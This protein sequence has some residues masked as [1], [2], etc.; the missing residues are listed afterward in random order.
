MK[1]LASDLDGTLLN[2][3]SQLSDR[4]EAVLRQASAAGI[5]IVAATGRSY[6]TAI[7]LFEGINGHGGSDIVRW[8]LCSNGATVYDAAAGDV[9]SH[10]LIDGSAARRILSTSD[11]LDG[12]GFA[13]ETASGRFR[14]EPMTKMM[15]ERFGTDLVIDYTDAPPM[16]EMADEL[17]KVLIF[18][19]DLD[20]DELLAELASTL[21]DGMSVSSSGFAFIEITAAGAEKGAALAALCDQLGIDRADTVAFGDQRNDLGMISWAGRGYAMDN[22]HP[23]VLALTELRAPHHNE[24]GVAVVVEQLL[25]TASPEIP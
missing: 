11:V 23:E 19:R 6:R 20:H 18:H 1:L 15:N 8:F 24:D 7:P 9:V 16:S 25:A 21:G 13:W 10:A 3:A 2:A 22:A 12:L 5:E 4:T 17:I 14:D